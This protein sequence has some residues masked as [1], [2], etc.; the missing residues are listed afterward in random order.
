MKKNMIA[1][2]RVI[3]GAIDL[4]FD[5]NSAHVC[6]LT[7]GLGLCC[8]LSRISVSCDWGRDNSF[9][10][11]TKLSL[12]SSILSG[13]GGAAALLLDRSMFTN[14]FTKCWFY[15]EV[16]LL[17]SPWFRSIQVWLNSFL[18]LLLWSI[19]TLRTVLVR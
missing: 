2:I 6:E 3:K 11:S 16:A 17:L 8:C 14:S 9:S 19:L 5:S 10:T 13:G 1:V 18:V 4:R 15:E 12:L 7:G